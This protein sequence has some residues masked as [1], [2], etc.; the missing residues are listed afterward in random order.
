ML[1]SEGCPGY[2]DDR[3]CVGV[4]QP[5][6]GIDE[7]FGAVEG[8]VEFTPDLLKLGIDTSGYSD[9]GWL[10]LQKYN[11]IQGTPVGW[12][13]DDS[14]AAVEARRASGELSNAKH[15]NETTLN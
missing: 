3:G 8:Y 14:V 5:S 1:V 12:Y 10:L 9:R 4:R 7:M 6:F 2:L 15:Q 11:V 13:E